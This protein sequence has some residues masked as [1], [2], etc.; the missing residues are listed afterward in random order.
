MPQ[1]LFIIYAK[2]LQYFI[3]LWKRFRNLKFITSLTRF[4]KAMKISLR[5]DVLY[6]NTFLKLFHTLYC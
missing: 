6:L 4:S 2:Q 3:H 1:G 5:Y